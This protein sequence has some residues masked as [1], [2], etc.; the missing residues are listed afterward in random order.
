MAIDNLIRGD[1]RL[2]TCTVT[3][4]T[5]TP[6]DITNDVIT[7]TIKSVATDLDSTAA[8]QRAI[9]AAGGDALVGIVKFQLSDTDTSLAIA[10]YQYDFQWERFGS[11]AGEVITL[12]RGTVSVVQDITLDTGI[13]PT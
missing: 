6:I 11:G 13:T 9:L 1:H 10:S 2:L 12:E 7:L 3:D 5:G 8:Y 4:A